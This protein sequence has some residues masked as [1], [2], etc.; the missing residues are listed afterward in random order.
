MNTSKIFFNFISNYSNYSPFIG[1]FYIWIWSDI[2]IA[3]C[4]IWDISTNSFTLYKI[5]DYFLK[6]LKCARG[7]RYSESKYS[8]R[9]GSINSIFTSDLLL[10]ELFRSKNW[11]VDNHT[12][13]THFLGERCWP[14]VGSDNEDV[15]PWWVDRYYPFSHVI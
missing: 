13:I 8:K 10:C 1:P 2:N 7:A 6:I 9:S 12:L 5:C 4:Q 3:T 15:N 14:F 11:F